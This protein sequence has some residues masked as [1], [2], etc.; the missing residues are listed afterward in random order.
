MKNKAATCL[1]LL[2]VCTPGCSKDESGTS[3]YEPTATEATSESIP[4]TS[5][6]AAVADADWRAV[7]DDWYDNGVIDESHSCVA[8]RAAIEHVPRSSPNPH[9]AFEDLG[10]YE[11][12]GCQG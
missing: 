11:A 8:V 7:I 10:R 2:L 5:G 6:G 12:E 3:S 4:Q 9:T 1:L